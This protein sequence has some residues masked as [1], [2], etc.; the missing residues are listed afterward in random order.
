MKELWVLNRNCKESSK[1]TEPLRNS[2]VF[3]FKPS[4]CSS[5]NLNYI[6]LLYYIIN[7]E[8]AFYD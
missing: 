8:E 1:G 4:E 6:V 3:F 5:N 2:F 7:H